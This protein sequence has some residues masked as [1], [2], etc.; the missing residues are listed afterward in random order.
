MFFTPL[1]KKKS[2]TDSEQ[3]LKRAQIKLLNK[4]EIILANSDKNT[5]KTAKSR[6]E[7]L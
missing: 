4:L 1:I 7:Q 2:K 6:T 3:V 5:H